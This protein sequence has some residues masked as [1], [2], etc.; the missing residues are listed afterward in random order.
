[1]S[2]GAIEYVNAKVFEFA[3]DSNDSTRPDN[4]IAGTFKS[5]LG[6]Q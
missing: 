4:I 5:K 2:L 3:T 6:Y 1:M